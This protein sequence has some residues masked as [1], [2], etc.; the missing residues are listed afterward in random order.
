M[1]PF[2]IRELPVE[3]GRYFL[4]SVCFFSCFLVVELIP[5]DI[6]HVSVIPS[7]LI[8]LSRA[9]SHMLL[10]RLLCSDET[11]IT[12]RISTIFAIISFF[13]CIEAFSDRRMSRCITD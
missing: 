1:F 13:S 5:L 9:K 3:M 2:E 8:A 7:R 10:V 12:G 6:F 11:S 4:E